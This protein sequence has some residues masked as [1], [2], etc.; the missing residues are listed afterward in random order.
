MVLILSFTLLFFAVCY[1][2]RILFPVQVIPFQVANQ[3]NKRKKAT[4]FSMKNE[5][6]IPI[7]MRGLRVNSVF[8][9]NHENA[10]CLR[11][12]ESKKKIM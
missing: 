12:T 3:T 1:S 11:D 4:K 6:R 2:S 8:N 9:N 10:G 7:A 5:K